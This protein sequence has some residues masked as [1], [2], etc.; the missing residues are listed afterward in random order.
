MGNTIGKFDYEIVT[1]PERI[2]ITPLAHVTLKNWSTLEHGAIAISATLTRM[3]VD[4]YI[5]LLKADLEGV[6]A[7]AKRALEKAHQ[8]NLDMIKSKQ[9]GD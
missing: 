1:G 7:K 8:K 9:V 3:E 6:G 5:E 2:P 4:G